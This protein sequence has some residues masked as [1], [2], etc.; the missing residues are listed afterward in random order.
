MQTFEVRGENEVNINFYIPHHIR[1]VVASFEP[2]T[3]AITPTGRPV[4]MR[5]WPRG[6]KKVKNRRLT[7]TA[8][9]SLMRSQNTFALFDP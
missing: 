3:A 6:L 7:A 2:L 1:N 9:T 8:T 5:M 4:A